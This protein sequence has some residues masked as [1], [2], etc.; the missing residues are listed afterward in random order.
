[1]KRRRSLLAAALTASAVIAISGCNTMIRYNQTASP[2]AGEKHAGPP[3]HAPAHGYRHK[4]PDGTQLEYESSMGVYVVVGYAEHYYCDGVYY[5]WH[6]A[7]WHASK[8]INKGWAPASDKS[9]PPGLRK[10]HVC[11]KAK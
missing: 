8:N 5:R 11:K 7:S 3:P 9:I 6:E 4:H 2:A 10:T 1:M